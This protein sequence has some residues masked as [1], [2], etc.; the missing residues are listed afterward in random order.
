[1]EYSSKNGSGPSSWPGILHFR[2]FRRVRRTKTIWT[3]RELQSCLWQPHPWGERR[4]T[5]I[6]VTSRPFFD[7]ERRFKGLTRKFSTVRLAGEKE[8][9]SI[10][11]EISLVFKADVQKIGT[12]LNRDEHEQLCLE[13]ELLRI[14]HQTYLWLK[15][16]LDVIRTDLEITERSLPRISKHCLVQ[17]RK[18]TKQS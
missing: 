11:K 8:T 7:T 14:P 6:L 1:M 5:E 9:G 13:N 18:H 16:I 3:Y 12:D 4:Q 10:E 15:L 2:C 17:L